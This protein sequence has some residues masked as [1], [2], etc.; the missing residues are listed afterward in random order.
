[1]VGVRPLSVDTHVAKPTAQTDD[2]SDTHCR[3]LG[4]PDIETFDSWRSG[5]A[6][7]TM[8]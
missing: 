1:V 4:S 8:S 6:G 7:Q 2:R 3:T 5:S